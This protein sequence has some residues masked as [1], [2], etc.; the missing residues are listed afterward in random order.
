MDM[1]ASDKQRAKDDKGTTFRSISFDLQAIL[2]VPFSS[3][4]QVYYRRKLNV[5]NFTIFEG[6]NS[7]GECFVWDECAGS[8]GSSEIATCLFKYLTSLPATVKHVTTYSD[9]CGGQNGNKFF[10]AAMLYVVNCTPIET[11]DVKYMESGHSY[12]EADSIHATI[13]RSRKNKKIF[14]TREWA[15]LIA[16]SRRNPTPYNVSI[17]QF[18]D[19]YNFKLLQEQV[20][21][22]TTINTE[23]ARVK[24]LKIKWIRFKKSE[25]FIIE[26][27]YDLSED[28]FMEININ[29]TKKAVRGLEAFSWSAINLKCKYSKP[30]PISSTKKDDLLFL[31]TKGVI[32]SD[33][34][35]FIENLPSSSSD[36]KIDEN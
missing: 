12:L 21:H 10:A 35:N 22:N 36:L 23:N 7:N 27:K 2:S 31:L 4:N 8:K 15:L 17:M 30:N 34:K 19:F 25:P 20:L 32:P 5:Y 33:Y 11:I 9:T 29:Q 3:D 18:D 13:E 1:K 6:H 26:Y 16:A 28:R 24:W 14:T